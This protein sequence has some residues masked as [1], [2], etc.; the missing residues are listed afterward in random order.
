MWNNFAANKICYERNRIRAQEKH[1]EYMNNMKCAIKAGL[2]KKLK[3]LNNRLK[4]RRME[5]G[6]LKYLLQLI[7]FH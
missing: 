4:Q 5:E 7:L 3:F 2:P 1:L 6:K